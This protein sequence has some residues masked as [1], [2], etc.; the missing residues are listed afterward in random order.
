MH[1]RYLFRSLA[2]VA[3]WP[4]LRVGTA[5]G[6]NATPAARPLLS[7]TE[8]AAV[9][10]GYI[11]NAGRVDAGKYPTFRR[12]Q[13]CATCALIEFGTAR[14][15]GCEIVPGRVVLATGWCKAWK[16]RGR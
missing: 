11:E 3:L 12:G 9:A 2:A 8:P 14:A 15:R 6:Q 1:R 16:A 7:P 10:I 4:L 5:A 13:S